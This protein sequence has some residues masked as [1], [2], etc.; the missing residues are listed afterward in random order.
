MTLKKYPHLLTPGQKD[1]IKNSG[2]TVYAIAKEGG[3]H[4]NNLGRAIKGKHEINVATAIRIA[5]VLEIS[6]EE[7]EQL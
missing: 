3:I 2:K 4:R 5:S 7:F 6:L 1:A